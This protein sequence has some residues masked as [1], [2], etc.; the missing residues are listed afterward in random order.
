MFLIL[1]YH[2]G[3]NALRKAMEAFLEFLV[4]GRDLLALLV[5]LLALLF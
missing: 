2:V 1:W 5:Q 4:F 3:G